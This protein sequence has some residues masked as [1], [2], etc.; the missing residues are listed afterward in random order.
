MMSYHSSYCIIENGEKKEIITRRLL[1]LGMAL[2]IAC[3]IVKRHGGDITVRSEEGAGTTFLVVLPLATEN[4]V[5][6]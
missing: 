3:D 1:H 4:Q 5:G 6:G 2:Y